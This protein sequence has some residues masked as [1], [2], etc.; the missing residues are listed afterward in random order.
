MALQWPEDMKSPETRHLMD[1]SAPQL[2][3]H[4]LHRRKTL[5]SHSSLRP[6][7]A[8]DMLQCTGYAAHSYGSRPGHI[9]HQSEPLLTSVLPLPDTGLK[10]LSGHPRT[11]KTLSFGEL[12]HLKIFHFIAWP[13]QL[14]LNDQRKPPSTGANVPCACSPQALPTPNNKA[15]PASGQRTHHYLCLGDP[16]LSSVLLAFAKILS[17]AEDCSLFM[18]SCWGYRPGQNLA[19]AV[20]EKGI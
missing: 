17:F 8:W 7:R 18:D 4:S 1:L 16:D 2:C 12:C 10:R 19:P 3:P 14:G 15:E 13:L 9:Q 20:Q 6:G 11:F 5:H